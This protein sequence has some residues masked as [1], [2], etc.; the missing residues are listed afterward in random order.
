MAFVFRANM[1]K[2]VQMQKLPHICY[3]AVYG[4]KND[5]GCDLYFSAGLIRFTS[6][7]GGKTVTGLVGSSVNF[8]WSF[9]FDVYVVDK[10]DWG[11]KKDG[12]NGFEYNG[13]LVSLDNRGS[14]SLT[15]PSA[16]NGRASG[17]GDVFSGYV[18]F[19]VSSIR[20]SDQR[21]YGCMIYQFYYN[22][23][24]VFDSV[25]LA[26]EEPAPQVNLSSVL[27]SYNEGS[28][29]NIS[30][31]ASGTP[32]PHVKWIRNGIVKS[33]GKKKAFLT[34]S[35]TNRADAGMYIC[36]ANNS[37]GNDEKQVTLVVPY[38]PTIK[39]ASTSIHKSRIGQTVTLKCV[40]DGVP[41]PT[42]TWYKSDGSQVTSVTATQNSVIVKTMVD[43]DF[44]GY[45]CAADNGLTP[46]DYRIV[47]IE[48]IRFPTTPTMDELP[49]EVTDDTI[50]LKWSEPQNN[51]KVI[52]Q[53]T[54]YQRIVTDGKPGAWIKL[55]TI[56][57]TSVRQFKVELEKGK[58][59]EFVVTA[60][61]EFGESS[62]E[63]EKIQRIK[64]L[65]PPK[66]YKKSK[67][68]VAV[69]EGNILLL[70][71]EAEGSPTPHVSWRKY[72]KVLQSS[73][74]KTNFI[75]DDASKEDAGS[76]ECK[77]S[78]SVGTVSHTVEVTVKGMSCNET[79]LH[80]VYIILLLLLSTIILVLIIILR[81]MDSRMVTT[82]V[83]DAAENLLC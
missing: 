61:N 74:N 67:S 76:Y 31:T 71:C 19:T 8:T 73:I 14:V 39:D 45:K 6:K 70:V 56:T 4:K 42:L 17:S 52:E 51:D 58:A 65:A 23:R 40:S 3:P 26:V 1:S 11:L 28:S 77:V 33:S 82:Y 34:F 22:Y 24:Q 16:Y 13:R 36:R 20:K 7:Y 5:F 57:D 64:T 78:N 68:E 50:T 25:Y 41:T 44:G 66:I 83:R 47:N 30:C 79:V 9:S 49:S 38:P 46:A 27:L 12:V 75:I 15:A 2:F 55:Q 53:Y 59:Y 60:T 10:V 62:K 69:V 37:A 32:D 43:Q 29:V 35:S 18:I 80:I 72:G 81:R 54:V 21:F 48:Q 63:D